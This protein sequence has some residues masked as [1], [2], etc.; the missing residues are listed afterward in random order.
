LTNSDVN[1]CRLVSLNWNLKVLYKPVISV[2]IGYEQRTQPYSTAYFSCF[3]SIWCMKGIQPCRA[4]KLLRLNSRVGSSSALLSTEIVN[5]VKVALTRQRMS[6]SR[7]I[8]LLSFYNSGQSTIPSLI[9]SYKKSIGTDSK[10]NWMTFRCLLR[11][12]I[13]SSVR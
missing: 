2:M 12:S 6:A 7:R 1:T 5:N 8:S 10:S 13:Y 9:S 3:Y 11:P 4:L